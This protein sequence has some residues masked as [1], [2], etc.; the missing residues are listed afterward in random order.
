MDETCTGWELHA[1]RAN[2]VLDVRHTADVETIAD[3]GAP[4]WEEWCGRPAGPV[5][6]SQSGPD[7]ATASSQVRNGQHF[8]WFATNRAT[9]PRASG[10]KR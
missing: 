5:R 7:P 6:R 2:T 4:R 9:R 1:A 3:V 8:R 10:G